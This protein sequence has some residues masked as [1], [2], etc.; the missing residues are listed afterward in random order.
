MG[1]GSAW[2]RLLRAEA[3]VRI[4]RELRLDDEILL[5]AVRDKRRLPKF[6]L[7]RGLH[8][9]VGRETVRFMQ[10]KLLLD[11]ATRNKVRGCLIAAILKL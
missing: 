3:E 1:S 2:Y 4:V 5:R 6:C 7:H 11:G 10:G 9:E 8:L